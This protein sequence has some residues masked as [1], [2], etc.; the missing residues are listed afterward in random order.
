MNATAEDRAAVED[1][2]R[3]LNDPA[4]L[5]EALGLSEGATRQAR[6]LV[7]RCPLHPDRNPSCSVGEKDGRIVVNCHK[8]CDFGGENRGGDALHLVAAARGLD[9]RKDF[10]AV[11]AV[12]AGLAG[13]ELPKRA[14]EVRPRPVLRVAEPEPAIDFGA[15]WAALE[16]AGNDEWEY[17]RGRGLDGAMDLC[18]RVPD[19]APHGFGWRGEQGYRLACALRDGGGSI[20]AIQMRPIDDK[21]RPEGERFITRGTAGKGVF[22]DPRQLTGAKAVIVTEGLTD[23]LAA[24]VAFAK[25][26]GTVVLGIAGAK[27]RDGL[28][29]LPAKGVKVFIG[30]DAD[31]AGDDCAEEIAEALGE[32]GATCYRA[33]PE[34]G[35]DLCDM[36]SA[37]VDLVAF[38][39]RARA[40]TATFQSLAER[41]PGEREERLSWTPRILPFGVGLLDAALGGIFPLDIV[42]VGAKTGV[43]KTELAAMIADENSKAGKRVHYFALEAEDKEIERRRKYRLLATMVYKDTVSRAV[44][45]RMNFLDWY[46]GRLD[47]ITKPYEQVAE[48]ALMHKYKT[49]HTYYRVKGFTAA[50]FKRLFSEIRNETDLIVIDHFHVIDNDHANE[51]RG[52]KQIAQTIADCAQEIGKPVVL[53]AHL[54]KT[55][56]KQ[57]KLVPDIDDF[58][59]SS[60]LSKVVKKAVLLAPAHDQPTGERHLWNT[61]MNIAKCRTDGT[62]TRY[63]GLVVF[64]AKT[65]SYQPRFTLGRIRPDK[66]GERF[67]ALDPA[68]Y[69][70]WALGQG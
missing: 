43:G 39:R 64:D 58:H 24:S 13:V 4:A 15:L 2:K 46:A 41:L 47:D 44:H 8:G 12:A 28:C 17:L 55:D 69:P 5:V 67:E 6:G 25:S 27:A 30:T 53:V 23:F 36:A 68:A 40:C 7:I 57:R 62:R 18:R 54:R 70:S 1:I 63:V 29:K 66:N 31:P 38:F 59:G 33:R 22:G 65:N 16:P 49:L 42:L 32:A 56:G 9:P 61:Y 3:R 48:E 34:G 45:A 52:Q 51:N 19:S 26:P 21:P 50:D 11:L 37:G 35:K 10:P 60:D 14:A 20:V